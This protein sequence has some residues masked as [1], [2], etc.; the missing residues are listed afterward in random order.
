VRAAPFGTAPNCGHHPGLATQCNSGQNHL[1][2]ASLGPRRGGAKPVAAGNPTGGVCL[3][4]PGRI[5]AQD[6]GRHAVARPRFART[7]RPAT[8]GRPR[9]TT[10]VSGR[11][12]VRRTLRIIS[13]AVFIGGCSFQGVNSLPLPGAM[14]RGPH[15]SIY[16]VEL[17]NVGRLESN[18][19][20]GSTAQT[21]YRHSRNA[22]GNTKSFNFQWFW[23]S[24]FGC[25]AALRPAHRPVCRARR[26][27]LPA[28]RSG[29]VEGA[30]DVEGHLITTG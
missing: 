7:R 13:C 9:G 25:S 12:L 10:T 6:R 14:G 19:P 2:R 21:G 26:S 17:A 4:R 29:A 16:H 22:V 3:H 27:A 1:R 8:A 23:R 30:E 15:A 5:D 11:R 18:S 24:T 28:V 20:V